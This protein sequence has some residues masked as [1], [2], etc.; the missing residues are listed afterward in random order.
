MT[1]IR[2]KIFKILEEIEKN[3][4]IEL[5][6]VELK[7]FTEKEILEMREICM[8]EYYKYFIERGVQMKDL[9]IDL[10]KALDI[11]KYF[12]QPKDSKMF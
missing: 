6:L 5:D 3:G 7:I 1:D 2:S 9:E 8:S 11:N 10:T 4:F 12:K